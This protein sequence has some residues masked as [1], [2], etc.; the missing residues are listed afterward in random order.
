M[1]FEI[2]FEPTRRPIQIQNWDLMLVGDTETK[3]LRFKTVLLVIVKNV[4]PLGR[5]KRPLAKLWV[6][7]RIIV[8]QQ[9]KQNPHKKNLLTR[10][11]EHSDEYKHRDRIKI[12][13]LRRF[14]TVCE[15]NVVEPAIS[16]PKVLFSY[17]LE[18]TKKRDPVARLRR[19][20]GSIGTKAIGERENAVSLARPKHVHQP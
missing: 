11:R 14:R 10:S 1:Q 3:G 5:S 19:P 15:Q 8:T 9:P 13:S 17:N 2:N 16:N 4:F 12:R 7:I 18:E 20:G 6:S